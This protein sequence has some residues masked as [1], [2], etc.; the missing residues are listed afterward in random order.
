MRD[1]QPAMSDENVELVRRGFM[2]TMEEDWPTALATLDPEV[3]VLTSTF[4]TP[5]STAGPMASR[6]AKGWAEGWD[7]WSVE[8]IEFRDAGDDQS[9]RFSS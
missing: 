1:T 6:L 3:E 9:S 4:R 8:D 2:A 5:V 7:S